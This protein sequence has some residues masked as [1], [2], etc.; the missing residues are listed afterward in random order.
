MRVLAIL[1]AGVALCGTAIAELQNVEVGG[2][3]RIR[4]RYWNNVNSSVPAPRFSDGALKGRSLG[5]FG[6]IGRF[7]WDDKDSG[8]SFIEQRTALHVNAS[9]TEN[10]SAFID[11]HYNHRWGADFR[12]DLATGQDTTPAVGRHVRMYQGYIEATEI[13]DTPVRVRIGRQE[14]KLGK[15][16][17]MGNG[18]SPTMGVSFD[19]LRLTYA[20]SDF[21]VDAF[22]AKLVEDGGVELDGDVD[23]YGVYADY[24]GWEPLSISAYWLWLRD[25]RSQSDTN[26]TA[27]EEWLESWLGLDDYDVSNLHT[28][29]LR[30][31]GGKGGWDYDL[32]AAYQFGPV[33]NVGAGF[34]ANIYGDDGARAN[35]WALDTETG[36]TADIK[37]QPRFF[38]GGAWYHG[39]DN[40]DAQWKHALN[41]NA[42]G[43][44]SVSFNRLFSSVWYNTIFD[45]LGQP[46]SN[47]MEVRAGVQMK[48]SDAVSST[49]KAGY[50]WADAPFNGPRTAS[51]LGQRVAF[52]GLLVPPQQSSRDLGL[53]TTVSMKYQYS[54]DL[55]I[56]VGWEH[57][58]TGAGMRD[59]NYVFKNGLAFSGGLDQ[60]DADYLWIDTGLKF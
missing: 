12:A 53:I 22:F 60:D 45:V 7:A 18:L 35:T 23:L 36:Y 10:V 16:F 54:E 3:L 56:S 13:F 44:A 40:R 58:F 41:P 30:A 37:F 38:A 39:E 55:F 15:G 46:F 32:E 31:Y 34:R 24:A 1:M 50:Y 33:D 47:F 14:M 2:E 43:D 4:G 21:T 29:G 28:V 42:K 26:G 27:A 48:W 17:L 6:A 49:L 5:P 51:L 9:F 11:F 20:E 52:G 25:A 57:L 8:L 19:A 59:G